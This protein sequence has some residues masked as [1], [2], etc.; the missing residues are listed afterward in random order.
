VKLFE[1]NL[2]VLG[3]SIG[4]TRKFENDNPAKIIF[5]KNKKK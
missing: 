3:Q 2:K 5:Q 4:Q 1:W